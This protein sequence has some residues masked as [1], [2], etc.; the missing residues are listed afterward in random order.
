MKT[1]TRIL[2][3]DTFLM[4]QGEQSTEMYMLLSGKPSVLKRKGDV[5][6]KIG[7]I[8]PGELVGEMSFIDQA[9]RSV[10]VKAFKESI[11]GIIEKE[12]FT[13][14]LDGLPPWFKKLQ[15]TLLKRLR[16]SREKLVI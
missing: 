12:K 10:D 14:F 7:E 2:T 11:V 8:N 3:E 9:P 15:E 6:K 1:K 13:E 4:R 5:E 16:E